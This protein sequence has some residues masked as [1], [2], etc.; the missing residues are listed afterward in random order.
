MLI[1]QLDLSEDIKTLFKIEASFGALFNLK[2]S[3]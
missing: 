1:F 2:S 3:A